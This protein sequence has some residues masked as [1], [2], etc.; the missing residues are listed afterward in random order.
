MSVCKAVE[1]LRRPFSFAQ[2]KLRTLIRSHR[3]RL[4]Q[5]EIAERLQVLLVMLL[6]AA[7]AH[8]LRLVVVRSP[9]K[10]PF[11]ADVCQE[12]QRSVDAAQN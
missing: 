5:R 8:A 12:V 4:R 2:G 7:L 3:N 11:R 10:P 6:V 9:S 1:L